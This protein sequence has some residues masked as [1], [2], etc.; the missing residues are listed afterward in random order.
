MA[1]TKTSKG[2]LSIEI[3]GYNRVANNMRKMIAAHPTDVNEVM[4]GWAEDT[5]MFLK[6]RGYPTRPKPSSYRR[7]GR[8]ASSWKKEEVKPAVWAISNNAASPQ[9]GKF[10]ARWVVGEEDGPADQRKAKIHRKIWW[11]ASKEIELERA[12]KLTA[13]L[14]ERYLELWGSP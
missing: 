12:P 5:R 13:L 2:N 4:R 7:T 8:L 6:Q 9:S 1:V 10:Y 3:K 11:I 14:G